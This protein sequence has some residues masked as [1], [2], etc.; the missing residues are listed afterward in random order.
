MVAWRRTGENVESERCMVEASGAYRGSSSTVG[1]IVSDRC[2]VCKNGKKTN[3]YQD[4]EYF[5]SCPE[6]IRGW[7]RVG[8]GELHR[9]GSVMKD[10]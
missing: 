7:R 4:R 3:G 9:I 8:R 2:I 1:A 5:F 6:K 10:A